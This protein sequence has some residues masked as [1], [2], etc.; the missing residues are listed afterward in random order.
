M[1]NP[2][3][4]KVGRTGHDLGELRAIKDRKSEVCKEV[5]SGLTN[6]KRFTSGLDLVYSIT[7]PFRIQSETMWKLRRSVGAETPNRGKMLG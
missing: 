7:F 2:E 5:T 4:V 1:N 6:C 3:L